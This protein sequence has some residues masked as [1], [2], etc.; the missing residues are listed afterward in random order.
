MCYLCDVI[1]DSECDYINTVIDNFWN[2]RVALVKSKN[3]TIGIY[4][5]NK[6]DVYGGSCLFD[7]EY[8]YCPFCGRELFEGEN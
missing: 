1:Y 6:K 5:P 4:I 8:K 7:I 3:N 2:E